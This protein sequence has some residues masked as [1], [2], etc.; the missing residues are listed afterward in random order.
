ML[1][2][3][4]N[5]LSLTYIRTESFNQALESVGQVLAYEPK[6]VKAL[7]RKAQV[8]ENKC[9]LQEAVELL[10]IAIE[11]EPNN[12]SVANQLTKLRKRRLIELENEKRMYQKMISPNKQSESVDEVDEKVS[13]GGSGS[14]SRSRADKLTSKTFNYTVFAVSVVVTLLLA[15]LINQFLT[16]YT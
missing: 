7:F 5:N 6:N 11:L 10:K 12:A 4:H 8:L 9:E 14:G 13:S 1:I 3:T 15:F 16:N 2:D